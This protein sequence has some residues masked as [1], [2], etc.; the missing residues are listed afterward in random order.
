MAPWSTAYQNSLPDSSFAWI[1]G[2]GNRHLPFKDANGKVDLPHVRNALARLNQVQGMGSDVQARVRSK[3]EALLQKQ[4]SNMPEPVYYVY[5]ARKALSDGEVID[6][7]DWIQ[8]FP[9]GSWDTEK[10]GEIQ[11]SQDRA[12]RM[13]ANFRDGVRVLADKE[14]CVDYDHKLDPAK[15]GKAAGWIK[16]V[17]V[18]DDGLYVGVKF[19]SNAKKEIEDGEWKYLSPTYYDEFDGKEDVMAGLALTNQPVLPDVAPLNLSEI[20]KLEK[21]VKEMADN[22]TTPPA[23]PPVDDLAPIRELLGLDAEA[24]VLSAIT[25]LKDTASTVEVALSEANK[26]KQLAEQY[27]DVVKRLAK[28]E[29]DNRNSEAREF[30]M[31]YSNKNGK[32]LSALLLSRVETLHKE[33]AER[34]FP[35]KALTDVLDGI[36]EKDG[37]VDY[38][39][40]GNHGGPAPEAVS[41]NEASKQLSQKQLE[42]M[43]NDNLPAD[44]ALSRV[45]T[46][47]PDLWRAYEES[48]K[49]VA[50]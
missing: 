42:Y 24:D 14:L 25:T 46:E 30:A 7:L 13:V 39:E 18:R 41:P 36:F 17:E 38:V 6:G 8:Y 3:L 40:H 16:D 49:G 28:L 23:D 19:T 10:Y 15:G 44:K 21:E 9:Y 2:S 26:Q 37:I 34:G 35:T 22:D 33:M 1:D 5:N 31:S 11:F 20:D 43:R 50:K 29:T 48:R 47:Q 12:E 4:G 45:I 27:P 32:G